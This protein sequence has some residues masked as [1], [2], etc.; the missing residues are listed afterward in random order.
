MKNTF[1][2][3]ENKLATFSVGLVDD[4]KTLSATLVLTDRRLVV[5]YTPPSW[6]WTFLS[7]P[8]FGLRGELFVSREERIR[9]QISRHRYASVEE[10]AGKLIIFHDSG[11]GYAHTSFAI[12][13]KESF[14]E[15]HQRM[16]RWAA[17]LDSAVSLP[18]ARVVD[19]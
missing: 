16:H 7:K 13:S 8:M 2:S 19:R 9:Y 1:E 12:T 10:G 15:W 5:L 14:D 11:E 6:L 3:G 18:A 4:R 17:G